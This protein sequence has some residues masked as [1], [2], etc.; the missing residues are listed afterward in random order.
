MNFLDRLMRMIIRRRQR[1]SPRRRVH[2][3]AEYIERYN[4]PRIYTEHGHDTRFQH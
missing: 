2:L 4:A 3:L 1:R